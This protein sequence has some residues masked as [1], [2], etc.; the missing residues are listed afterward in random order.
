M[1]GMG[2]MQNMMK[3]MQKM[4]K[5]M[6]EAQ[7]ELGEKRIEGTAGGGMVTVV[8]SGHKEI[9]EVN[10][11]EEVVDPEDIEMLQDLVLAAT[12]DA[13]KKVEELTNQTMGQFTK[14]LN[15]PGF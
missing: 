14:G 2:N 3:Q 12:N 8:V 5:K 7:E 1:R 11:K 13:L 15:I 6:A 9:V 10:I 4:Q